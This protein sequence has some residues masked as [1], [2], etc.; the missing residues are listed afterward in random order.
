MRSALFALVAGCLLLSSASSHAAEP[1]PPHWQVASP[2]G[3]LVATIRQSADGGAEYMVALNGRPVIEWSPLG[4]TLAWG[5]QSKPDTIQRADFSSTVRF[6]AVSKSAVSDAYTMVTGKR[7]SNRYDANTLLLELI[8]SETGR[9][10]DLEFQLADDG[11]AFR[12]KLPGR[13]LLYSWI[14]GEDTGFALGLGGTHWGQAYDPPNAWQPA[15]E[16]PWNNGQ[17]IGTAV[18]AQTGPGWTIPALFRDENGVWVLLHESGLTRDYHASHLAPEAPGGTYR[19]A[20][21]LASDGLG[22]GDTRPA[23]TAPARLPWRFMVISERLGDIAESNRV[24]DLAPPSTAADTAWI[25]PGVSSWSWL[26]DHDSSQSLPKLK[27]FIDLAAHRG[28]PYSL[29][30]A[31]WNRI[32]PDSLEQLAA[33]AQAKN[34]GLLVWYNSGGRHN[35][36]T[37]EPRN[38]MD[39]RPRRRAEF[40][41]LQRLGVKGVKIDFF[42]SDK[43]DRIAQYLEILEDAAEFKLLVN[44]HGCTVP[45]GWQRTYPHLMTMEAVRGGE[46]YTFDSLPDFGQLSTTQDA[47]LPFTR[48]AIGSMDF[49]PV[50]FSKQA[51]TR[52]TTSAHEAALGVVFESGIQHMAD[53]TAGYGLA[54]ADYHRYLRE[55]PT[56]WDETRL[57]AGYPGREA[58]FARRA[59]T[60]WYI[61]GINGEGSVKTMTFDLGFLSKGGSALELMDGADRYGFYSG[62]RKLAPGKVRVSMAAFGGFVWVIDTAR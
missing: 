5:D 27:A 1:V 7:R 6:G 11:A 21:P 19:I 39:D 43:Q 10:L 3:K 56:V 24:F 41:K 17:P 37:E 16:S 26:T 20:G 22:F 62:S 30:D 52:L 60:R 44:F 31:N 15:Y 12:Y 32:A 4:L 53:S 51:R 13:S 42:Q 46:H 58:V 55:L 45:R 48:N 40:A 9:R 38:L 49:T 18:P 54:S 50:L 14:E 36:V 61:A 35:A 33:H 25:K 8:D 29:V 57:L 2:S 34:V 59:G 47:V 23:M 28:W